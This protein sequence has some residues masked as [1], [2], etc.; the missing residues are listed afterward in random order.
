VRE[1]AL[2]DPPVTL[3][4]D[5][6]EVTAP[7]GRSIIEAVWAAGHTLVEHVGCLGQGVCGSC[8]AMVR[9][10]GSPEVRFV[11][12]CETLAEPGMLVSFVHALA[13]RRER[14]YQISQFQDLWSVGAQVR[15]TFPEAAHC[16]HCGGCDA[17]CPRGLAVQAGVGAVVGGQLHTAGAIFEAC[18]MCNLCTAA[19][20][21]QITPNHV[22][23]FARRLAATLVS[24]PANLLRRLEQLER[25]ELRIDL[26]VLQGLEEGAND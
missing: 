15:S 25:G 6:W 13:P 2:N 26:A 9:R 14:P 4:V 24:R 21:E 10:D 17:V 19:C 11:L 23:L 8:R 5:G 20:P 1:A 12:A 16:R 7:A 18:I 22:G 3:V